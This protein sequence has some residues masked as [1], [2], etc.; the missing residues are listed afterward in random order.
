MD[1]DGRAQARAETRKLVKESIGR[2]NEYKWNQELY[3][4]VGRRAESIPWADM[5]PNPNLISWLSKK[6]ILSNGKRALVIGCGLGDDAEE[7]EKRALHHSM[8][9]GAISNAVTANPRF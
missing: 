2:G 1:K 9:A 3:S 6:G 5:V 7:P 8:A 4:R